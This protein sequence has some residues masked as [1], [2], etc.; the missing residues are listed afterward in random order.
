MKR[1]LSL[2]GS[3]LS[4]ISSVLFLISGILTMASSFAVISMLM[5]MGGGTDVGD[6]FAGMVGII[7]IFVAIIMI[8]FAIT[9]LVLSAKSFKYVSATHEVYVEKKRSLIALI[10]LNFILAAM[11][12]YSIIDSAGTEES[13]I[14]D[15]I[16]SIIC[17][18]LIVAANVFF[19]ID[20]ATE[21]KKVAKLQSDVKE[22]PKAV[23][24]KEETEEKKD[25]KQE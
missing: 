18:L 23:E 9:T 14:G 7:M 11:M 24:V 4:T 1:P 12:L 25:E 20:L 5:G 15:L 16:F 19:I 22:E 3:I 13:T 2:T 17:L 21:K 8:A 10:V 6:G